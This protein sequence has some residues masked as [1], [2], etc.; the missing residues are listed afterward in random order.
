MATKLPLNPKL[1]DAPELKP[2]YENQVKEIDSKISNLTMVLLKT[3]KIEQTGA[4]NIQSQDFG[5]E[6]KQ[7]AKIESAVIEIGGKI[8][9]GK[10]HMKLY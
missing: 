4:I 1:S 6:T 10:N 7:D 2:K 3:P 5:A 8:Y 9:E